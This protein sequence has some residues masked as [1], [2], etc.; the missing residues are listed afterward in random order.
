MHTLSRR[1]MFRIAG[2][3]ALAVSISGYETRNSKARASQPKESLSTSRSQL[4]AAGMYQP[5]DATTGVS[6]GTVLTPYNQATSADIY[7]TNDNQVF[8]SL[9]IYGRIIIRAENTVIR[10]CY[11]RGVKTLPAYETAIVDCNSSSGKN[12]LIEDC[13]IDPQFPNWMQNGITGHEF[14]ARRNEIMRTND[15]IGAFALPGS[16]TAN[17]V[18]E[19]NWIHALA[20]WA[21]TPLGP[22]E[23]EPDGTHNDGIQIQGGS[24]IHVVGN[25]IVGNCSQVAGQPKLNPKGLHSNGQSIM[26]QQLTAP[27][28]DCVI[29]RNWFDN[30][31]QGIVINESGRPAISLTLTQNYFGRHWYTFGQSSW[32]PIRISNRSKAHVDGLYTNYWDGSSQTLTE[33]ITAGIRY[34]H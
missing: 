31:G 24:S 14:T 4:G 25:L 2:V 23:A 29:Q 11:L 26:I 28:Q 33:G 17:V 32:Y 13:T 9:D 12:T 15:G 7:V 27:L 10:N 20:Y 16:T 19:S 1:Q 8:D 5:S 22:Y 18:I 3:G 30:A 6:D 21:P 34:D